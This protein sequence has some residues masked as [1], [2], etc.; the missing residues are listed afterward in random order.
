MYITD[1]LCTY[2]LHTKEDQ[3]DMYRLQLLQAFNISEFDD[4]KL[5][6]NINKLFQE[7]CKSK[8]IIDIVN[9]L[10]SCQDDF[11]HTI[12]EDDLGLFKIL[13]TFEL[14]NTTHRALCHLLSQ[15]SDDLDKIKEHLINEILIN[16]GKQK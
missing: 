3:I 12:S 13:F 14:F 16:F 7:Q 2:K 15:D 11:I 8:F 6:M 9:T 5:D 1:F 4:E 10:K